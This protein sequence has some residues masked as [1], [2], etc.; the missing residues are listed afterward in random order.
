MIWIKSTKRKP[1]LGMNTVVI[2]SNGK[3]EII[4]WDAKLIRNVSNSSVKFE[5]FEMP[6]FSKRK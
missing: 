1:R 4:F 5:W 6:V 3:T 2:Y